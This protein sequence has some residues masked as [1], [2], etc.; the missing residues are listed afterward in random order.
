MHCA[1][2]PLLDLNARHQ[3]SLVVSV[4]SVL[5]QNADWTRTWSRKQ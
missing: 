3:V 4:Q 2:T 1:G 5:L